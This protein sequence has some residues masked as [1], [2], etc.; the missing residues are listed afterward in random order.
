MRNLLAV[1]LLVAGSILLASCGNA[2]EPMVAVKADSTAAAANTRD[3]KHTAALR[4]ACEK[5]AKADLDGDSATSAS[6]MDPEFSITARGKTFLSRAEMR[7]YAK[8]QMSANAFDSSVKDRRVYKI[9]KVEAGS[10]EPVWAGYEQGSFEMTSSSTDG[11]Y[12]RKVTG[13]YFRAWKI[14]NGQWKCYHL[15]FMAFDC[16]GSDCD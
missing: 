14:V 2:G 15:V 13:P 11:K 12:N 4:E 10:R 1:S 9:E 5:L 3:S 7:A 8:K 6:L 16:E